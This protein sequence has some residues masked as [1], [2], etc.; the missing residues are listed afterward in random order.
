MLIVITQVGKQ[1]RSKKRS[2][3]LE[4]SRILTTQITTRGRHAWGLTYKAKIFRRLF[5]G[6]EVTKPQ[7]TNE[8]QHFV[9]VEDQS[10]PTSWPKRLNATAIWR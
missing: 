8:S 1:E 5:C 6:N 2:K 9:E 10:R 7:D 4:E 3:L